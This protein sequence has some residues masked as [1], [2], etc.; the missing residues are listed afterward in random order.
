M[1]FKVFRISGLSQLDS[2]PVA[3]IKDYPLEKRDYKPYA[4]CN[5]C[6]DERS[7][8][9]RMW[10][11]EVSP[12][13]GSEL[14]GVFYLFPD[15]PEVALAV[16]FRPDSGCDFFL[17]EGGEQR[18]IN[19]PQGFAPHPHN[20]EDLQGIYWGGMA[21]LPLDWLES[22]GG[23]VKLGPGDAFPGNFYKLCPGPAQEHK[24]SYF[25]AD[26]PGDPYHQKSMGQF[27]VAPY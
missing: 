27:L 5:I 8:F 10:A 26:F 22:L 2:L 25:P 23:R 18:A 14:R 19:P 9:V 15:K 20:G 7:L 17:L 13:E 11:F 3:V 21:S 4:Q 16:S 6:L 12:P 24:G 1:S